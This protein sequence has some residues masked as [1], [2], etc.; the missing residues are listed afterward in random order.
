M[1]LGL[2]VQRFLDCCYYYLFTLKGLSGG[3]NFEY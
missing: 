3:T 1:L 2:L